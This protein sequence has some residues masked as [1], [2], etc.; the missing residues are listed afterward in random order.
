[1]YIAKKNTHTHTDKKIM[2]T[3][4]PKYDPINKN[5]WMLL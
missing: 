4:D 3:I 5:D 2:Y 1:M